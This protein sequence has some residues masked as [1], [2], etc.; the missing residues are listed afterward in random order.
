[1]L[2][3]VQLSATQWTTACQPPLSSTISRNLLKFMSIEPVM[4]SN[5]LILCHPLSF[6]L[7][8]FPESGSFP[9][10]QLFTSGGQSTETSTSMSVLPMNIQGWFPLGFTSLISL[11]SKGCLRVFSNTTVRKHLFFGAQ[12][13]LWSNYHI[14][15]WLL[16]KLCLWLYGPFLT[17]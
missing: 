4:P 3:H 17:K 16:E 12:P 15:T 5:Q 11:K 10:S 6:C 7:R 8:S 1:M 2:S 9:L 13:S 14:C